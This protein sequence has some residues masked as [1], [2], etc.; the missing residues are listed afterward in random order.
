MI[1]D[2][3]KSHKS[4]CLKSTRSCVPEKG[5][6]IKKIVNRLMVGSHSMYRKISVKEL[7]ACFGLFTKYFEFMLKH[8]ILTFHLF[9]QCGL[10][11]YS[12]SKVYDN[13][14]NK[15]ERRYSGNN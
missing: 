4:R 5:G 15:R 11:P 14:N 7:N 13:H 6:S 2:T 9:I 1:K 12:P 10:V 8:R 3:A